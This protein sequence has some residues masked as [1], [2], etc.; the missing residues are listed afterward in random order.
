MLYVGFVCEA[1]EDANNKRWN[2]FVEIIRF[3][4][5]RLFS[6]SLGI[7]S[8]CSLSQRWFCSWDF[9]NFIFCLPRFIYF[10]DIH[11]RS[12]RC[13]SSCYWHYERR[14][15]SDEQ[16]IHRLC[17]RFNKII[18]ISRRFYNW[19]LLWIVRSQTQTKATMKLNLNQFV[20]FRFMF[21]FHC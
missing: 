8:H 4:C 21:E 15:E 18:G 9:H 20:R 14:F 11:N 2:I 17:S 3:I 7:P 5:S 12:G 16:Q 1:F 10:D 6:L 19:K 13:T